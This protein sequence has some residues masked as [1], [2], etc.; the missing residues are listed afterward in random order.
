MHKKVRERHRY[1]CS[2][3]L[4]IFTLSLFVSNRVEALEI[5]NP[6]TKNSTNK[7]ITMSA[8]CA[9]ALDSKSKV[10]L[11]EKNAYELVPM[12]STTKIMTAL[13]A[14]KYGDLD[15]KIEVSSKASSMRGSVVGLRKGEQIS[16]KELI[17]GLMLRSGND[18]AVA[19]AEGISGSVEEFAKLM[20]EY[21]VEIGV[22]NTHFETPHGL[23]KDEHYSTAYDLAVVTAKAKENKLF[24]EIV[25]SKDVDGK[26]L[27][28]T[29]SYHNINKILWQMPEATGV[30][31][32]YT[33]KAGKCLVSSANI[34]GNDV[35]VVV[36]N[37][38][39]RWKE[40]IKIFDYVNKNYEFK[41]MFIKGDSAGEIALKRGNIKLQFEDDVVIPVKNGAEYTVKIMKPEKI[42]YTINKGD[43]IGKV[44]VYADGE[45]IYSNSLQSSDTFK[46]KQLPKWIK[47]IIK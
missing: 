28:F 4:F 3:L 24:N 11:Y 19:I 20:N 6:N 21:A 45:L 29:R 33:G 10:V 41:K 44:C 26:T 14:L 23:D 31:T 32:G 36:L 27:G 46:V 43:K 47:K 42:D 5:S 40:S 8:R 22:V 38:T 7:G 39:E 18:A 30:K 35:I 34:Q 17:Y 9:I 12:A 25:S 2:L 15:R 1:L 16:T 37:C 13:V